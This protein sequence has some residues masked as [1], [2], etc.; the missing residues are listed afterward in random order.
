MEKILNLSN[1][2]LNESKYHD[3]FAIHGVLY[4][5]SNYEAFVTIPLGIIGNLI[6][7]FIFTRPILNKKTNTGLLFT[8]L[9]LLNLNIILYE[10]LLKWQTFIIKLT[11]KLKEIIKRLLEHSLSWIQVLISFDRFITVIFPIKGV[12]LMNKKW[13]LFSIIIFLLVFIIGIQ[14]VH[15]WFTYTTKKQFN[16]NTII[17]K[18]IDILMTIIIPY[19]I[20]ILLD[21]MVIVRLRRSKN[22]LRARQPI[23]RSKS[24]RF[25]INTIVI[26][27]LFLICKLSYFL[28]FY[29]SMKLMI[30][31]RV[32]FVDKKV[33]LASSVFTLLSIFY[34]HLFFILFLIFNRIFRHE[35]I[36]IFKRNR[37]FNKVNASSS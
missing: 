23:R 20:I 33:S 17:F 18:F 10:G 1:I 27:L 36:S 19:L 5:I 35:F 32:Y 6:S 2:S 8:I 12:R 31:V 34:S 11:P 16:L 28:N 26:D 4:S 37:C 9:C 21:I 15:Y 25:T 24:F 7:I 30:E 29:M 22:E 3:K 14:L 13:F